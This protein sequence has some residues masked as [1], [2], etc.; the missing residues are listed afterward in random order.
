MAEFNTRPSFNTHPQT[1]S[2]HSSCLCA[3]GDLGQTPLPLGV[4]LSKSAVLYKPQW[5]V[6]YLVMPIKSTCWNLASHPVQF[7]S[8]T[9]QAF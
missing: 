2:A 6:A 3:S 5:L 4:T 9:Q 1:H 7:S 8:E